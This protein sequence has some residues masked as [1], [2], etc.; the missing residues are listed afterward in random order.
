MP[1]HGAA[2]RLTAYLEWT[3][4]EAS[5]CPS[6]SAMAQ[7]VEARLGRRVFVERNQADVILTAAIKPNGAA[8]SAELELLDSR[9]ATLGTRRVQSK[10]RDCSAFNDVLPIVI[11]LLVDASQ[12]I[13]QLE[14]P[15]P[16][17][18]PVTWAQVEYSSP[19]AV[20]SPS[21]PT[22]GA[23][24]WGWAVL[25]EGVHGLMPS[26][27]AGASVVGFFEPAHPRVPVEFWL[28]AIPAT[29]SNHTQGI[30]LWLIHL[31]ARLCPNLWRATLHWS[32][33]AGVSVG[34]LQV[35]GRGFDVNRNDSTFFADA[36]VTS[37][38]D[39]PIARPWFA[40]VEAGAIAPIT[41]PRFEGEVE[42]GVRV[43]LHRPATIVPR[44][45]LGLGVGFQ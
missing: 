35:V 5:S 27:A 37:Q 19:Q 8:W 44:I 4:P 24:R 41:R 32:V 3:A 30:Q 39:V 20:P 42:P 11:A 14:L 18:T 16:S 43:T 7:A 13:V 6:G 17:Y 29:V 31:G 45:A 40:R 28:G 26:T 21:L 33:C 38:L 9:H 23:S 25:G 36:R 2:R 12:N 34:D 15:P 10:S 1:A 22:D